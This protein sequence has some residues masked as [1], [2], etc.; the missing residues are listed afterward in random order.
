M[1][2]A[3]FGCMQAAL[4]CH[5]DFQN[6]LAFNCTN[7]R[8]FLNADV[9]CKQASVMLMVAVR[10]KMLVSEKHKICLCMLFVSWRITAMSVVLHM[11]SFKYME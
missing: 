1:S 2:Y 8:E 7:I 10:T 11:L 5:S 3:L 9:E 6:M 4:Q